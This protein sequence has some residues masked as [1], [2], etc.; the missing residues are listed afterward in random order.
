MAIT[1]NAKILVKRGY[2]DPSTS[3]DQGEPGFDLSTNTFYVGTNLGAEAIQIA[4]SA[5]VNNV[6]NDI[7]SNTFNYL[8]ESSLGT[9]FYFEGGYLE[10][11]TGFGG[12]TLGYV[13]GSL[14]IRDLSINELYI[15]KADISA[16]VIAEASI[17]SIWDA[18]VE[19]RFPIG[20]VK[21]NENSD[22]SIYVI[23]DTFYLEPNGANTGVF[24]NGVEKYITDTSIS[25]PNVEGFHYIYFD[26]SFNIQTTQI[27]SVFDGDE[28]VKIAI[29]YWNTTDS[30]NEYLCDQRYGIVMDFDTR[31]YLLETDGL[32]YAFGGLLY[33]FSIGSLQLDPT[34]D[35][36]A[37]FSVQ[38]ALYLDQDLDYYITN[39]DPQV[40]TPLTTS[41][42]YLVG[43]GAFRKSTSSTF[44]CLNFPS[45]SG[46]LAYNFFN[47]SSFSLVEAQEGFFV[48]SHIIIYIIP[49]IFYTF[50]PPMPYPR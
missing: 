22:S 25:I 33:D 43:P 15:T 34:S 42:Y 8:K 17:Y 27:K 44:P 41:V 46:R 40:L 35:A 37:Q 31:H 48:N 28:S 5:E 23:G 20:F 11:S 10:V 26:P 14:A 13:D 4:S 16:L 12:V 3:L 38:D 36:E 2:G 45:A 32:K 49:G 19:A 9:D 1:R 6:I 47:G 7:S 50:T 21:Y 29:T 18:M 24:Y 30:K 39:N